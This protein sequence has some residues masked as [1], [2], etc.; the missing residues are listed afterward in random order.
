[1]AALEALKGETPG[2]VFPL[3]GARIILGRHPQCEVVLEHV[4]VSRQHAQ[5]LV[6]GSEYFLED[7]SSRNG[8]YVNGVL[9]NGRSGLQHGDEIQLSDVYLVFKSEENQLKETDAEHLI[10]L[11][12][13]AV[14]ESRLY[15]P[16][17]DE[18]SV[19][20]S[21]VNGEIIGG[22]EPA[23]IRHK[24]D[25]R[26]GSSSGSVR[27]S[28]LAEQKLAAVL[29][30][31]RALSRVLELDRVLPRILQT[32]FKSFPQAEQGFIL[33]LDSDSQRLK[34][35]AS[36]TRND[37]QADAVAVSMTVVRQAMMSGEAILSECVADD[38]RFSAATSL[39]QL[40]IT[41]VMCVPLILQD[42]TAIGVIQIDSRDTRRAFN[43]GDLE[44]L[45]AVASQAAIVVENAQLH[46]ERLTQR[47]IERDLDFARQVQRGFLPNERP[48]LE[49]YSFSDYYEA[50]KSVGGDYYDYIPLPNGDIAVTLGDVA[51]KGVSAA[52]LMAR[53][54]S[55]ARYLF[56]IH[57]DPAAAVTAL[58]DDIVTS[59]LGQRFITFVAMVLSPARGDLTLI[60]AG[61]MPP[62]LRMADGDTQTI[63]ESV[64]S[65]P[66]GILPDTVYASQTIELPPG[67]SVMAFT[68]GITEA[69]SSS[70][71]LF[72]RDRLK[73]CFA[74]CDGDVRASMTTIIDAV[75]SFAGESQERD[76]TCLVMFRRR[77]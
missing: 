12:S 16:P 36:R 31:T 54:Y 40:E 65:L 9:V 70:R 4:T 49:G 32:L 64:S 69:M 43:S 29:E 47:D 75:R 13:S 30:I 60:N 34:V 15:A 3:I 38:S 61:H 37:Q 10:D 1:M 59:G 7:L 62:I 58:N 50:A 53:L 51:G 5:I 46:Q 41:S 74:R 71:E 76:D 24:V 20:S 48:Q 35:K 25:A 39:T 45:V 66:L 57:D 26:T 23:E 33:L 55:S 28:A 63:S 67:S 19:D 27:D 73:E 68:D 17:Q 72:G 44:L 77:V 22:S 18:I 56:L 2:K 52:L 42:G 14:D 11:S 21:S 6:T 8:T